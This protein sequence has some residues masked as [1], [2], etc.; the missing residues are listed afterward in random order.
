LAF[1]I[2]FITKK[3]PDLVKALLAFIDDHLIGALRSSLVIDSGGGFQVIYLLR[4]IIDV[5]SSPDQRRAITNLAHDFE[6][7]L[8]SHVPSSL[9]DRI[10]IDSMSNA[11]RVMRLPGTVNPKAEKRAKGQ[12]EALAHIVVDYRHKCDIRALRD[13][14]PCVRAAQPAQPKRPYVQRANDP[15]TPFKKAQ[16]C[17]EYVRDCGAADTNEWYSWNVM[18]PLLGEAIN[19]NITW[20]EAE[21]L[22]LEAVN[23]GE[24][25][26]SPG[27]GLAYFKRQWRSHLHS[28]RNGL[29]TLGSLIDA[30][31]KLGMPIPWK[32]TVIWEDSYEEQLAAIR[33]LNQTV[34]DDVIKL[35]K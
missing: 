18:F 2:D 29:R 27:R 24:R 31:K 20:D 14:V 21:D 16:F 13:H 6:A 23:G 34:D 30:C 11:D 32:D 7:L 26:G 35:L 12:E 19:G 33:K 10:K 15:W 8:R 22:F 5:Q 9:A 4:E 1:D 17:C 25:Y 3:D 28:S